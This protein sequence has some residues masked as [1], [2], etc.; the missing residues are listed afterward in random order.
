[1]SDAND[2]SGGIEMT[3]TRS[4]AAEDTVLEAAA[5]AEYE[6]LKNTDEGPVT[7][8]KDKQYRRIPDD[9]DIQDLKTQLEAEEKYEK[10][11]ADFY[12]QALINFDNVWA[13]QNPDE[14]TRYARTKEGIRSAASALGRGTADAY[15]STKGF[16]KGKRE[17]DLGL[18][19]EKE[20]LGISSKAADLK[21]AIAAGKWEEVKDL[22][23]KLRKAGGVA[24]SSAAASKE[25]AT[26]AA[27]ANVAVDKE[28]WDEV[29]K[30]SE[31]IDEQNVVLG[32]VDESGKP[33]KDLSTSQI[34]KALEAKGMKSKDLKDKSRLDLLKI[35]LK[36]PDQS[37][38]GKGE[39]VPKLPIDPAEI[40]KDLT[41]NLMEIIK[42]EIENQE[43]EKAKK[44]AS[45]GKGIVPGAA[46]WLQSMIAGAVVM[47]SS[48]MANAVG[49]TAQQVGQSVGIDQLIKQVQR[50]DTDG[51]KRISGLYISYLTEVINLTNPELVKLIQKFFDAINKLSSEAVG[52]SLGVIK[53]IIKAT[54]SAVPF[55]G[56]LVLYAASLSPAFRTG[57]Q[58]IRTKEKATVALSGQIGKIKE[59]VEAQTQDLL[60]KLADGTVP[61]QGEPS[62]K[63]K[64]IASPEDVATQARA[65]AAATR[66]DSSPENATTESNKPG[67]AETEN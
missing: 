29:V 50:G 56:P 14:D 61:T 41:E 23:L 28:K 45:T 54:V 58:A 63:P 26:Y 44:G 62:V 6:L 42:E 27:K 64:P 43:K 3:P 35:L 36:K 20:K 52:G 11:D 48:M 38:V 47:T 10:E 59:I 16:L 1:M 67:D 15:A 46:N 40:G 18:E 66:V 4:A 21:R 53:N 2:S 32:E 55:I 60:S 9:L 8:G 30:L 37:K 13:V 24:S 57:I 49:L 51:L 7:V 33:I 31:E 5:P 25:I 22:A 17:R 19:S 34:K 65:M 39:D 12:E